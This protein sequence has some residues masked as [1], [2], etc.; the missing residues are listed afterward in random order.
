VAEWLIERIDPTHDRSMFE[1]E[2][3]LLDDFLQKLVSQ[4]EKR[5]LGRTYVAVLPPQKTV[6][7]Y[8]TL[9]SSSV[10]FESLPKASSKKLPRHSVPVALVARLAVDRSRQGRGLGAALLMDALARCVRLSKD[11]A[12]WA[13]A[14]DAIDDAAAGFY[15]KFG[16]A[17]LSDNPL[18]LFLPMATLA[19]AFERSG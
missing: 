17:P 18:S 7:G 12:L 8:Y 3:P 10:A 15:R 9:A 14:V 1:S 11:L 13:V 19:Q 4:Y 16:F 6:V 5:H 2:R